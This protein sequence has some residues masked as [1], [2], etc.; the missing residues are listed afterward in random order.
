MKTAELSA[1]R[2]HGAVVQ[3]DCQL[4]VPQQ[5]VSSGHAGMPAQRHHGSSSFYQRYTDTVMGNRLPDCA[6]AASDH[7]HSVQPALVDTRTFRDCSWSSPHASTPVLQHSNATHWSSAQQLA[8]SCDVNRSVGWMSPQSASALNGTG[9]RYNYARNI[10]PEV[11]T[12]QPCSQM[13]NQFTSV[14]IPVVG[15]HA[16]SMPAVNVPRLWMQVRP[17]QQQQQ[18]QVAVGVCQNSITM[19]PTHGASL[20]SEAQS[21]RLP[22][23][24]QLRFASQSVSSGGLSSPAARVSDGA[25]TS[26]TECTGTS[27]VAASCHVT[28]PSRSP[29]TVGVSD[30]STVRNN[31]VGRIYQLPAQTVAV[32]A[33]HSQ[34]S[35]SACTTSST[36]V[37]SSA[38]ATTTTATKS[39]VSMKPVEKAV[40]TPSQPEPE[41]TTAYVAG[42]RYTV[43]KTDGVTV[44]GIWDGK[45]LTVLS[46]TATNSTA[47]QTQGLFV[48]Y[49]KRIISISSGCLFN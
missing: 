16:V 42:R 40:I 29:M 17:H 38:S 26:Q 3:T 49:A 28:S 15:L 21:S 11:Y 20:V 44:E 35:V 43:T 23:V 19:S 14:N 22:T 41:R 33:V 13:P 10:P 31:S 9:A 5:C 36:S 18:Q 7:Q 25:V 30:S 27:P 46:T 24:W 39:V 45:Y 48:Y 8:P 6:V 1:S 32:T 34:S 12:R 4:N 2:S 37:S 47:S